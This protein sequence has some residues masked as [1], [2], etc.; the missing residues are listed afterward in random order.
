[1]SWMSKRWKRRAS[2]RP[3]KLKFSR[4]RRV[5]AIGGW[6]IMQTGS[7]GE[8]SVFGRKLPALHPRKFGELLGIPDSLTE[9]EWHFLWVVRLQIA[10]HLLNLE[11]P[12]VFT[13]NRP[14]LE[15]LWPQPATKNADNLTWGNEDETDSIQDA[16]GAR[17]DF[18][19][20]LTMGGLSD[21]RMLLTPC[22]QNPQISALSLSLSELIS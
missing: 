3:E 8:V 17:L 16:A 1:M 2:G 19:A 9:H 15:W 11:K 13:S 12:T 18:W 4:N 14:T 6:H 7:E 10:H 22:N 5:C 20:A 21:L